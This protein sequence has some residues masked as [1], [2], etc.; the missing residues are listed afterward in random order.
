MEHHHKHHHHQPAAITNLNRAFAIGISLNVLFVVV[1]A[2]AG[3][4]WDSMA[5]LG[6][7]GHNLGD[8]GSLVLSL[9]AFRLAKIKPNQYFTYGYKKTTILASLANSILLLVA[10]GAIL[11]ETFLRIGQPIQIPGS[12]IAAVAGI[13]IAVNAVSALLF[14][15]DR[16]KDINIK[17]AYLHLF[18]DAMVSAGVVIGGIAM[19]YT[20]AYWIDLVLGA[21]IA[22]VILYSV[23]DVLRESLR[24]SVNAVPQGIDLA[25]VSQVMA[26][27]EKVKAVRHIHI[28]P[29]STTQNALTAHLVVDD[30]ISMG[31]I[32]ALKTRIRHELQHLGIHHLTL[33]AEQQGEHC[34]EPGCMD[35]P[36][37]KQNI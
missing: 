16:K 1:E 9:V 29:I 7:A 26:Q 10:V 34:G 31:E 11:W 14:F 24:L 28:W 21:I 27:D 33:E 3:F 2:I 32:A 18:A 22:C 37:D 23:W 30:T 8:V 17:G 15:K 19:H 6:D 36:A 13:G 12:Q 25:Q 20:R 5:L 35:Y 4:K